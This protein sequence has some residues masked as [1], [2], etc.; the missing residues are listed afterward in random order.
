MTTSSGDGRDYSV[1]LFVRS[2]SPAGTH[3][4]QEWVLN[5]LRELHR[6]DHIAS[7]TVT[8]WGTGISPES[9]I[10][11]T[12][13]GQAILD[14]VDE[15]TRWARRNDRSFPAAFGE[16]ERNSLV[17]D[18]Q[19]T[20]IPFPAMCLAVREEDELRCVTPCVAT[21]LDHSIHDCLAELAVSENHSVAHDWSSDRNI[22]DET[23]GK[24]DENRHM[25]G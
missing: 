9:E 3:P 14:T 12:E 20:V 17:G 6:D 2:L 16:R 23:T 25:T 10:A 22:G 1:E 13:T 11:R 21:T 15:F 19:Q 8:V 18:E 4:Q 5:R 7:Y 24:V